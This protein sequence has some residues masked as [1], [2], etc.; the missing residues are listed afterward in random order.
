M[1][2]FPKFTPAWNSTCFGQFLCPSSGIYSLY[3]RH[4]YMSYR[5]VDSFRAGPGWN[6]VPFWSCSKAVWL[7]P[8]LSVQW[9]NC[10]WWTEELP[11]TCRVSCRCKFGKLVHLVGFIINKFVMMPG[12]MNVK[13]SCSVAGI[14]CN[15]HTSSAV[16]WNLKG[17]DSS[18][19][20]GWILNVFWLCVPFAHPWNKLHEGLSVYQSSRRIRIFVFQLMFSW[21][22]VNFRIIPLSLVTIPWISATLSAYKASEFH[23]I[24][25]NISRW[26]SG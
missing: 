25:A 7:I 4:W 22:S 18:K 19:S 3:T 24:F 11:E 13:F 21:P 16:K 26:R 6:W 2:Q 12:H 9:M 23:L 17:V 1:H 8:L 15:S 20:F 14:S 10:W 5:F